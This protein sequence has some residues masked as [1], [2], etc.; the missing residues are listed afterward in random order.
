[1]SSAWDALVASFAASEIA[2]P[3]GLD[4]ENDATGANL[5]DI[6]KYRHGLVTTAIARLWSEAGCKPFGHTPITAA[7]TYQENI[8]CKPVS[9]SRK[10]STS[11]FDSTATTLCG[12]DSNLPEWMSVITLDS[13]DFFS[14]G[15][16]LWADVDGIFYRNG[17]ACGVNTATHQQV[18][19]SMHEV[20]HQDLED[21]A[22]AVESIDQN[23]KATIDSLKLD[24]AS[25]L[26][27]IQRDASVRLSSC[28][29]DYKCATDVMKQSHETALAGLGK[30]QELAIVQLN[31]QH[32]AEIEKITNTNNAIV[33]SLKKHSQSAAA[34][35]EQSHQSALTS[36]KEENAATVKALKEDNA[37]TLSF[38]KKENAAKL[39]CTEKEHRAAITAAEADYGSRLAQAHAD[40]QQGIERLQEAHLAVVQKLSVE[41]QGA[42]ADRDSTTAFL[43][44]E[45][46]AQKDSTKKDVEAL[47]NA[48]EIIAALKREIATV[49][50]EKKSS[51][52]ELPSPSGSLQESYKATIA[53]LREE[54]QELRRTHAAD[55]EKILAASNDALTAKEALVQG[56]QA[57]LAEKASVLAAARREAE[58][59]RFS[60]EEASQMLN[61]EREVLEDAEVELSALNEENQKLRDRQLE[62]DTNLRKLALLNMD[63]R[64]VEWSNAKQARHV[65]QL[66]AEKVPLENLNIRLH[67]E[68]LRIKEHAAD[69]EKGME[70]IRAYAEDVSTKTLSVLDAI[71]SDGLLNVA[72]LAERT[73]SEIIDGLAG[74][75]NDF[76]EACN[77]NI[78]AGRKLVAENNRLTN[79]A[80]D[81]RDT[82]NNL[83][84][85]AVELKDKYNSEHAK[86]MDA[87]IAAE[88]AA[89]NEHAA[90]TE[91]AQLAPDALQARERAARIAAL[92]NE[93]ASLHADAAPRDWSAVAAD[94]AQQLEARGLAIEALQADLDLAAEQLRDHAHC[95]D[96][97]RRDRNAIGL[98]E[99]FVSGVTKRNH[100]QAAELMRVRRHAGLPAEHCAAGG[101]GPLDKVHARAMLQRL[102]ECEGVVLREADYEY[103][104]SLDQI[105]QLPVRESDVPPLDRPFTAAERVIGGILDRIR[106]VCRDA[107]DGDEAIKY[108]E[109]PALADAREEPLDL[110][111]SPQAEKAGEQRVE[112]AQM[113]MVTAAEQV[114]AAALKAE[115]DAQILEE[116][117]F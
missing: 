92:E 14:P 1:M 103:V 55:V 57:T 73:E 26:L 99:Q 78:L 48:N 90:S 113:E 49:R 94:L 67:N 75:L 100:A 66:L 77:S 61:Q 65:R 54:I 7:A 98:L 72:S 50:A 70:E 46:A 29:N 108:R 96:R 104:D 4:T 32:R 15:Q 12:W 36:L 93:L 19:H 74:Y 97:A 2:V 79:A 109:L 3:E 86:L 62:D 18:I 116:E 41:H 82:I 85:H 45:L 71:Q 17:H 63:R 24:H 69:I 59:S 27:A 107:V 53:S 76:L 56:L 31:A 5:S 47:S 51:C 81:D 84:E 117:A 21:L 95:A 102:A 30:K 34:S 83:R 35:L 25:A 89:A 43:Y 9:H 60:L 13:S 58:D 111:T 80:R 10:S 64:G 106:D 52:Q 20:H 44:A 87:E 91:L 23:A 22:G 28:F 40:N 112:R 16:S 11:S 88:V 115:L 37:A 6:E 42:L 114:R 68:N 110:T 8:I 39:A 101:T 33:A 105:M 38:L